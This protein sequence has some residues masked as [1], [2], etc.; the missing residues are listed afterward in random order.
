MTVFINNMNFKYHFPSGLMRATIVLKPFAAWLVRW[1]ETGTGGGKGGTTSEDGHLVALQ[2]F[3]PQL[4]DYFHVWRGILLFY[5][6]LYL[7]MINDY[8]SSDDVQGGSTRLRLMINDK[9]L[10]GGSTLFVIYCWLSKCMCWEVCIE[11]PISWGS[12]S[13]TPW[14]LEPQVS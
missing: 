4:V 5:Y 11:P 6:T 14:T 13:R 1:R 9:C 2:Q 12:W 3:R 7:G 8:D 10:K